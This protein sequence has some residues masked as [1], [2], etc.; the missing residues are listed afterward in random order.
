MRKRQIT[1]SFFLQLIGQSL[2]LAQVLLYWTQFLPDVALGTFRWNDQLIYP[3]LPFALIPLIDFFWIPKRL[4]MRRFACF[5]SLLVYSAAVMLGG[6]WFVG[7]AAAIW[8]VVE[9]SRTPQGE[10]SFIHRRKIA[11]MGTILAGTVLAS[12]FLN[13]YLLIPPP[14]GL[15]QFELLY[16]GQ[17]SGPN[18]NNTFYILPIYENLSYGN[19]A[20]DILEAE[21]MNQTLGPSGNYVKI[22]YSCSCWYVQEVTNWTGEWQFNESIS[23]RHKIDFSVNASFPVLFHMNGGNWGAS[24]LNP[25]AENYTGTRRLY[26]LWINESN[27]QWNNYNESVPPTW[28]QTEPG[29]LNRMFT[30][31]KYSQFYQLREQACRDA[32]AIIALFAQQY[33]S[34]FVGVSLDS[35]IHLSYRNSSIE[36]G[37]W[38]YDY[39]PLV[40]Q[41]F[42]EWLATRYGTIGE[43]N[44]KFAGVRGSSATAFTDIDAPRVPDSTNIFWQEWTSF[45]V[46]F[47]RMNVDDQARWINEAGI[48]RDRI[49][50]HQILAEEGDISAEDI[51]CDPLET[52]NIPHGSP[53]VT[54]YGFIPPSRF[55]D[56]NSFAKNNWGIFEFNMPNDHTYIS[57]MRMLKAMYESGCHVVCPYAW[58]EGTWPWL[59]QIKNDTAFTTAIHDFVANTKDFPRGTAPGGLL[60]LGDRIILVEQT[61]QD[62]FRRHFY[63]LALPFVAS[64]ALAILLRRKKTIPRYTTTPP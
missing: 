64:I 63:W 31:S 6:G 4:G 15:A 5:L 40:I 14:V 42:Q 46:Q 10:L 49:Y 25:Y 39:N 56:I 7:S 33:P 53:G 30:L 34:L 23:L 26:D 47:V 43:F 11:S 60:S 28:P 3:L 48:P 27:V 32:A 29:L 24:G 36:D 17:S 62:Y 8:G 18:H 58:Y 38:R 12:L 20:V 19:I 41:E 35:E 44:A 2:I 55:H 9:Y 21:Y 13:A 54:K 22:G 57:Y 37:N 59:Y 61:M 52:T 51:R 1:R 16:P 45:R 50:T